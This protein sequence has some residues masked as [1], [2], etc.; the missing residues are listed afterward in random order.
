MAGRYSPLEPLFRFL[1]LNLPLL[2]KHVARLKFTQKVPI[3]TPILDCRGGIQPQP[4]TP[5]AF[6]MLTPDNFHIPLRNTAV[7]YSSV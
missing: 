2:T 4:H 7:E 1:D 5:Q 3:S 6:A